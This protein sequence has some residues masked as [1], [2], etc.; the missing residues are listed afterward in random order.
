MSCMATKVSHHLQG[1]SPSPPTIGVANHLDLIN[2]S[3]VHN[4]P[5]VHHLNGARDVL[6]TWDKLLLLSCIQTACNN[7]QIRDR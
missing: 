2:H 6:G 7:P 3:H 4:L 1:P 5:E